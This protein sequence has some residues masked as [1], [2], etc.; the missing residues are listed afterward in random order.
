MLPSR[1]VPTTLA[2][3]STRE[4]CGGAWD[5]CGVTRY[6]SPHTLHHAVDVM[7]A[8]RAIA[9][10]PSVALTNRRDH[11]EHGHAPACLPARPAA[12]HAIAL[13]MRTKTRA[14]DTHV[15]DAHTTSTRCL[16]REQPPLATLCSLPSEPK[17]ERVESMAERPP[18]VVASCGGEHSTVHRTRA[19]GAQQRVHACGERGMWSEL[20]PERER[21]Y[22]QPL[23]PPMVS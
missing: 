6:L 23:S 18:R 15:M 13:C 8:C 21:A 16:A 5:R 17:I 14:S 1:P 2:H 9:T 7:H 20:A 10:P 19:I 3:G 11:A 12:H 4:S 22:R